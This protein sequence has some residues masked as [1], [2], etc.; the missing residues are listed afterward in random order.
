MLK[1]LFLP[2]VLA[3][4]IILLIIRPVLGNLCILHHW[5]TKLLYFYHVI[6]SLMHVLVGQALKN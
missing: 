2:I 6:T 4:H 3:P 5:S 1:Y